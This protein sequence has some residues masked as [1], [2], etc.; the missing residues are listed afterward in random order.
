MLNKS[1]IRFTQVSIRRSHFNT[2]GAKTIYSK[3]VK[4]N[5]RV[6]KLVKSKQHSMTLKFCVCF[7]SNIPIVNQSSFY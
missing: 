2:I 3:Q 6:G 4:P 7:C 1:G 5:K